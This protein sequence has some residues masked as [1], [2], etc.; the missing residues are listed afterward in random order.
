MPPLQLRKSSKVEALDPATGHLIP[1]FHPLRQGWEEHFR[2]AADGTI[3]GL[4]SVGRASAFAL[5][6]NEPIA[7]VARGM[8]R[9]L[10]S[11]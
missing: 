2:Q 6:M 4:T 3:V 9:L 5:G 8:Q 10:E 7:K 11:G 1:L